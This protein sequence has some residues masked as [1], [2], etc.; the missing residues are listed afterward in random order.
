MTA[1]FLKTE[2]GEYINMQR[3]VVLRDVEYVSNPTGPG[4]HSCTVVYVDGKG[5]ERTTSAF[6]Y[7]GELERLIDL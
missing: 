6:L 7:G 5:K 1:K 4:F 3:I 2:S